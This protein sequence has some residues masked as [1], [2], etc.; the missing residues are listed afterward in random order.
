MRAFFGAA[1][2]LTILAWP[3]QA[4]QWPSHPTPGVPRT[5]D[6]EPDLEAPAPR[7]AWGTPDLSGIWQNGRG[8]GGGRGGRGRGRGGEPPEPPEGPP[9]PTFFDAGANFEDGLP[10]QP[11]AADLRA[12]RVADNQKDNPDAHCLPIGF[13]QFHLHPQ[14]RKIIQTPEEIV[15][16]YE[17]NYGVR[18]IFT[19]GR[20]LPDNDPQPWW[21]GYSVGHWEGDTLV[22]ETAGFRDGGW[23]DV[24]GSPFTDEA[25]VTERFTRLNYGTMQI[26]ITVDDPKAYTEPF[27]V[28]V[29]HRIMLDTDLIEFICLENEQSSEFY[30]Q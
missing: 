4:A 1:A 15:I 8:G 27:T 28:R 2:L 12:A 19:D 26:D 5:P 21:Y 11:W 14:P 24:Y 10:F 9:A 3:G 7:T 29:T 25:H 6:G 13:L 22:V 16:L 18:E 23:L 30:D 20:S 17:S